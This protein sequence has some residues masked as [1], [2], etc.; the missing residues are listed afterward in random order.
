MCISAVLSILSSRAVFTVPAVTNLL[1]SPA[2]FTELA[3]LGLILTAPLVFEI[4]NAFVLSVATD[5]TTSLALIV[6]TPLLFSIAMLS[7]AFKVTAFLVKPFTV[8]GVATAVVFPSCV[9]NVHSSDFLATS[10]IS[11]T[12]LGTSSPLPFT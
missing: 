4:S 9:R 12:S 8:C 11:V 6:T 5:F 7:P 3:N 1:A 10:L 2:A